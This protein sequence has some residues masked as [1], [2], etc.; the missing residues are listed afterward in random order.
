M[1]AAYRKDAKGAF[2]ARLA[3]LQ[4]ERVEAACHWVKSAANATST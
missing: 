1:L 2:H 4:K 3:K